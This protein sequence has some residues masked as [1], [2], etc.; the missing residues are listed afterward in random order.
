LFVFYESIK[1][2][3]KRRL[4]HLTKGTGPAAFARYEKKGD[5]VACR[6]KEG[7]VGS[8]K[9]EQKSLVSTYAE[10]HHADATPT[11]LVILPPALALSAI[12]RHRPTGRGDEPA[13][14]V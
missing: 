4:N 7:K 3:L 8:Q 5:F 13:I 11:P 14:F 1:R 6:K 2:E 10:Y 9:Q 12:I